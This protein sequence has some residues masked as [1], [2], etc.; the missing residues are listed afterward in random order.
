VPVQTRADKG[1]VQVSYPTDDIWDIGKTR[2]LSVLSSV[3]SDRMREIIREELGASYSQDAYNSASRA[4]PGYGVMSAVIR[5][6]PDDAESVIQ[7]VKQIARGI[8]QDGI[9]ADELERALDPTLTSIKDM[10][11]QNRYWLNTVLAGSR[12]H[13]E[14]LDW[15]RTIARDYGSITKAELQRLAR[16]YLDND[17][18]AVIII[19]PAIGV[20]DRPAAH[21]A[22]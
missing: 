22:G 18:A 10:Q 21:P 17:A 14:Q 1:V 6:S 3:L 11:Q 20:A 7:E 4:Y 8:V 5:V 19:R 12:E 2:R 15:S 13:P 9:T 16:Q